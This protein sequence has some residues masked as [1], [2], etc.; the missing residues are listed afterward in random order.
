MNRHA[1]IP[2]GS[3]FASHAKCEA[4]SPADLIRKATRLYLRHREPEL[5]AWILDQWP[6]ARQDRDARD[7]A[8]YA[9]WDHGSVEMLALA[10]E[11]DARRRC[12]AQALLFALR[13]LPERSDWRGCTRSLRGASFS[14][15][16]R[17]RQSALAVLKLLAEQ[18]PLSKRHRKLYAGQMEHQPRRQR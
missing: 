6:A 11:S 9:I 10:A 13:I 7:G 14:R 1:E 15:D 17:L 4:A 18:R 3:R 12:I 5:L 16:L 2:D 8:L